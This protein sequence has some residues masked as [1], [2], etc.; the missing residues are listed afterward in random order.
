LKTIKYRKLGNAL[1]TSALKID[2]PVPA[3]VI[4]SPVYITFHPIAT[5]FGLFSY[6]KVQF[7]VDQLSVQ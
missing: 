7:I 4:S 5:K 6:S 3:V 2:L 1:L